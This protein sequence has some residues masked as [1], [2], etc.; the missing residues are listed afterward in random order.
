M[1]GWWWIVGLL[2]L[3]GAAEGFLFQLHKAGV[4]DALERWRQRPRAVAITAVQ[5]AL[6]LTVSGLFA[7]TSG[8]AATGWY[9]A[10]L[11]IA[12]MLVWTTHLIL[13]APHPETP[14]AEPLAPHPGAE[15]EPAEPDAE[16][17]PWWEHLAYIWAQSPGQQLPMHAVPVIDGTPEPRAYCGSDYEPGDITASPALWTA[18]GDL[19][20]VTCKTCATRIKNVNIVKP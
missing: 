15:P 9:A 14:A 12:G 17:G 13:K 18:E 5:V 19:R 10:G 16:K 7:A 20:A 11:V 8:W 3:A 6:L 2:L 4:L 1:R